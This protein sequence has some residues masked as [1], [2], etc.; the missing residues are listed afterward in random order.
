MF[1]NCLTSLK[2]HLKDVAPSFTYEY[3]TMVFTPIYKLLKH[4]KNPQNQAVFYLFLDISEIGGKLFKMDVSEIVYNVYIYVSTSD[5]EESLTDGYY[6]IQP[7]L[8]QANVPTE[9]AGNLQNGNYHID[10]FDHGNVEYHI[11]NKSRSSSPHIAETVDHDNIELDVQNEPV[12]SSAYLEVPNMPASPEMEVPNMPASPEM[13]VPN[14]PASPEMKVP[15]M[16]AS[17]EMDSSSDND[18]NNGFG[19]DEEDNPN[20]VPDWNLQLSVPIENYIGDIDY[21]DDF[22]NH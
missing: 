13:K 1:D 9:N 18:N 11:Q 6:E 21:L 19:D 22:A 8:I 2:S 3:N 14:M 4:Q 20:T 12:P 7:V 10:H 17:L 15:N 16:P 5:N